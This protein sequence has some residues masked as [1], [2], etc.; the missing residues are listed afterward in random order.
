MEMFLPTVRFTQQH[1]LTGWEQARRARVRRARL[2]LHACSV[3][4]FFCLERL[5]EQS[6]FLPF[7]NKSAAV[8]SAAEGFSSTGGGGGV[9]SGMCEAPGMTWM[10]LDGSV[11]RGEFQNC[12]AMFAPVYVTDLTVAD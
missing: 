3:A 2:R 6:I 10:G 12:A 8:F 11:K 5:L 4:L 7:F 1:S 9:L